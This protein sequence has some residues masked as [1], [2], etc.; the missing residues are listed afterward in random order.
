MKDTSYLTVEKYSLSR[1]I[2]DTITSG[3]PRIHY[4]AQPHYSVRADFGKFATAK[5]GRDHVLFVPFEAFTT[6]GAQ[7]TYSDWVGARSTIKALDIDTTTFATI[8]SPS[9]ENS[10]SIVPALTG[11]SFS[12]ADKIGALVG[13][14]VA[15]KNVFM[16]IWKYLHIYLFGAGVEILIDDYSAGDFYTSV[17]RATVLVNYFVG[18]PAV[19]NV[20]HWP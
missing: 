20:L 8:T 14:E 13:N 3:E 17:I 16:G 1:A 11:G 10:W 6:L 2:Q 15:A 7:M 12:I 9:V 5:G 19:F 4:E 18:F